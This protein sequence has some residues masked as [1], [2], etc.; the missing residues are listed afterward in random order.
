MPLALHSMGLTK[1][2][3]GVKFNLGVQIFAYKEI[4]VHIS[5]YYLCILENNESY[6]LSTHCRVF[7]EHKMEIIKS[8]LKV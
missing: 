6:K 5:S 7:I 1:I 4:L 3:G 2:S 8:Y